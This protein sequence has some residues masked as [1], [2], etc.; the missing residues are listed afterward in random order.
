MRGS[1]K[2]KQSIKRMQGVAQMK[3]CKI[4]LL[5]LIAICLLSTKVL[6]TESS[7]NWF[8]G[9]EIIVGDFVDDDDSASAYGVGLHGGYQFG[10]YLKLIVGA[11]TFSVSTN[12]LSK[13]GASTVFAVIRPQWEFD[14]G[15]LVYF[16]LG[17]NSSS[18]GKVTEIG[19][20]LGYNEGRHEITFGLDGTLLGD[21]DDD[22]IGGVA[23]QYYFHF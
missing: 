13:T 16:D 20:G 17:T 10:N 3:T 19:L 4:S 6:A 14:S 9:S 18:I 2:N 7:S 23:L 15:F 22:S 5:A 1:P 12:D 21:G 11:N 8:V